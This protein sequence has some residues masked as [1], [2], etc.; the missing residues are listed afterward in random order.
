MLPLI[1]RSCQIKCRAKHIF[2]L[3]KK[4]ILLLFTTNSDKTSLDI[5]LFM[6][7]VDTF[8]LKFTCYQKDNATVLKNYK[9]I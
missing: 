5:F 1:N 6:V 4:Y 3:G 9:H 2:L 7:K 8:Q